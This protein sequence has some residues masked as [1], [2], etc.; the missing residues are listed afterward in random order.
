M[1]MRVSDE[2]EDFG[3]RGVHGHAA[4][5][6]ALTGFDGAHQWFWHGIPFALDAG[7]AERRWESIDPQPGLDSAGG[8]LPSAR[9]RGDGQRPVRRPAIDTT[10]CPGISLIV[11][12]ALRLAAPL[13]PQT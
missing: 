6:L 8:W 10:L 13:V 12:R 5:D 7:L 9:G 4:G 3:G 11:N 1:T 2:G